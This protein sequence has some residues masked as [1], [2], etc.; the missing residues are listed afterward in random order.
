MG[1]KRKAGGPDRAIAELARFQHGVI[2]R[3][4]LVECGLE[5][6]GISTRLHSG[7]L[8][9]LH[10]GV[11][12]V[13]HRAVTPEGLWMA[14]VFAGGPGAALSHH[15][16]ATLWRLR[17][18]RTGTTDVTV[19]RQRRS[20]AAVRFHHTRL[21]PDEVT[22]IDGIPVT[23]VPR[24]LFDLAAVLDARQ[25][26]R[27]LNEA[28]YLRLTDR[29]SLPNLLRRYPRRAGAPAV[30]NAL[31]RRALGATVTRSELEERFLQLV[32]DAGLP[33]PLVNSVIAGH[34]VDCAWTDRRLIVELDGRAAHATPAAF[35]ADRRRDRLLQAAGWRVVR[36]TWRQLSH[37]RAELAGDLRA[38][39]AA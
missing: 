31:E 27:A 22:V 26:E 10:R 5:R 39:L 29:L 13:G 21:P 37:Q 1:V 38:L 7:R 24:T 35:E 20:S 34:E 33:R 36:L 19:S 12:A 2:A 9:V 17:A 3:R 23:T 25:L 30:R 14:A 11:Y 28:D 15:A 18:H 8:H 16:A 4:Q 6:S 32:E